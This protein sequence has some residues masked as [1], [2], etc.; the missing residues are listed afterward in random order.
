MVM[1]PTLKNLLDTIRSKEAPKGYGQIY[2]GAKGV[3]LATD[4]SKMTLNEVLAFQKKMLAA[5]S[6]SSACGGYQFLRSTLLAT[7]DAMDLT[8]G[9]I[10]TPELQDR[11]AAHLME[12]RGLSRYMAGKI[13]AEAF[14]N[15]L[16]MEW[17]SL[18]VVTTIKGA[19][20][21]VKPGETYYAGDGLNKA[22]HD[23]AVI[24]ALVKALRTG[25]VIAP[26]EPPVIDPG[27]AAPPPGGKPRGL[28]A[29]IIDLILAIFTRRPS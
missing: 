7:I 25:A 20:R 26:S 12:G 8:G 6:A 17:A 15:N 29:A 24:L 19:H 13:V 9:E 3:S 14:A 5:R 4:V 1:D 27:P 11:M 23:P 28:L 2:G 22:R 18:P 21:V 16:A 10:W